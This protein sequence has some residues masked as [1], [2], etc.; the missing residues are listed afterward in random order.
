[1]TLNPLKQDL[2]V[3]GEGGYHTYRIPAL[4]VTTRGTL[5]AFCEG[6][7]HH[8]GDAGEID[9]LLRRS[10][11]GG[12]T[13]GETQAVV[14][15]ASMTCGNPAPV[16]DRETGAIWLPFCKN[17]ADGGE[18]LIR[19]GKALRTV[20]LTHSADD[21]RT[22][23]R[24]VEITAAVKRPS[25]T[26]YATGPCHGVQLQGGRLLVPCDHRTAATTERAE[27][28]YSHAIYSDDRGKTWHVGGVVELEGTNECAAV[29]L[30]NGGVYLNCR[31]QR[32]RG[33][34]CA[35]WS[36]DGG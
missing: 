11:D 24:P 2:W 6:R 31:D 3:G 33:R 27:E 28:L 15:E 17:R 1:M 22:W 16:V 14:T 32:N 10:T 34:R 8:G 12:A 25:W 23:A 13:W 21:G 36:D 35:A 5:L 9:L 20:W 26:W 30:E 29:E 18:A 4:A 7:K 19:Q